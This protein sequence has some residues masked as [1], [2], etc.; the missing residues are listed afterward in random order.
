MRPYGASRSLVTD[1]CLRVKGSEG[2]IFAMGDTATV[3]QPKAREY[4]AQLFDTF[5][6]DGSG[7]LSFTELR[8]LLKSASQRFSHLEEHARFLEEYAARSCQCQ[9]PC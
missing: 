8:A 6:R 3:D 1:E 4:A 9:S 7:T 5:D 2:T